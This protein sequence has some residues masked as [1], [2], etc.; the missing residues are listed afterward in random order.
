MEFYRLFFVE[1]DPTVVLISVAVAI[2]SWWTLLVMGEHLRV[3]E[4]NRDLGMARR[5]QWG[6][7]LVLGFGIWAF[8]FLG[9]LAWRPGPSLSFDYIHTLASLI[10]ALG[11]AW[12]MSQ[13]LRRAN[14]PLQTIDV[15]RLVA[16]ASLLGGMHFIGML[17]AD[18]SPPPNWRPELILLTVVLAL[19]LSAAARW[20][21]RWVVDSP[22]ESRRS[23]RGMVAIG[24]GLWLSAVHYTGIAAADYLPG[25]VCRTAGTL[26]AGEL[27]MLVIISVV[28]LFS[29]AL[30]L[31]ITDARAASRLSQQN[32]ALITRTQ[33]LEQMLHVDPATQLANRSALAADL[34]ALN[35][36]AQLDVGLLLAELRGF[37]VVCDSWGDDFA[38]ELMSQ[39][40]ARCRSLLPQGAK[41]FRLSEQQI[42]LL[43]NEGASLVGLERLADD[44]QRSLIAPFALHGR[45]LSLAI[46]VGVSRTRSVGE[47]RQLLP[48]ARTACE[49]AE[50]A[51]VSCLSFEPQMFTNARDQLE[52]QGHLRQAVEKGELSLVVQP[53][54]SALSRR[55]AGAEALLRWRRSDGTWV[56][57][58]QFIPVAERY[59]LMGAIGDWVVREAIAMQVG[60]RQQGLQIPL[61][62]NISPQQ[63]ERDSW[64]D[65]LITLLEQAGASP[66]WFCLEI[67][68]S[69]AILHPDQTV[70]RLKRLRLLGFDVSIDDFGTGHSSLSYLTRLPATELKIDRS[71]VQS[72]M[73]GSVPI[74][75]GTLQ[76]AKALG[77]RTVAEGVETEQQRECLEACGVEEL[78]GYLLAKP[79][80]AEDLLL[81]FKSDPRLNV[82]AFLVRSPNQ[83]SRSPAAV[84]VPR[85][86]GAS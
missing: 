47:L 10:L 31:T 68:E 48:M 77:M 59:G 52:L 84:W 61:S 51:G 86:G 7:C 21:K 22:L 20:A 16:F 14:K 70:A 45:T 15:L 72:L 6:R 73:T 23:R 37:Q 55:V 38:S 49:F 4:F 2:G 18:T 83:A 24:L 17:A 81:K 44:L 67:T 66:A 64:I 13:A 12:P 71:F 50:R 56:S 57:P 30:W 78:Q 42:G 34:V 9:M 54:F 26:S 63:L 58:A 69:A 3:G 28:V 19:G 25:T 82:N 62:I 8:H 60:W 35:S 5:W 79:M 1:H 41:L 53:K 75:R 65:D 80:P 36:R 29:V 40:A 39:A 74:V 27:T 32:T 46:L 76:M 33:V 11:A 85:L 43:V